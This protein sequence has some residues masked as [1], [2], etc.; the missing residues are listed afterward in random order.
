MDAGLVRSIGADLS[1]AN[2][3][4]RRVV[5]DPAA[6]AESARVALWHEL[7]CGVDADDTR[8]R[9]LPIASP[10][11]SQQAARRYRSLAIGIVSSRRVDTIALRVGVG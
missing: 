9:R 2:L 7:G 4:T 1:F 5:G 10:V 3:E 8:R 6:V 11:P